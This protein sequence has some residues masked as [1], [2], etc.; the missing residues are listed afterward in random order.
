MDID[1]S[2]PSKLFGDDVRIS[3]VIMNLLTNAVKYTESG[4]V[5]LS[6]RKTDQRKG[7]VD[8]RVEVTDTGIG[9]KDEDLDKLFK[10]FERIEERRNLYRLY[11][12]CHSMQDQSLLLLSILTY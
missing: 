3:Q 8:L 9:I 12:I 4:S 1:R 6:V 5:T 7:N 2:V 11:K 10:S